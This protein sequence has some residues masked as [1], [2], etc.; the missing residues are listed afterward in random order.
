MS[1]ESTAQPIKL[2][3]LMEFRLPEA[4]PKEMKDD[5]SQSFELVFMM[6]SAS[7]KRR[8]ISF[9][10]RGCERLDFRRCLLLSAWFDFVRFGVGPA[11]GVSD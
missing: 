7:S 3:Y 1:Y 11:E 4:Y 8:R 5:L 9:S 10:R 6:P 2:G